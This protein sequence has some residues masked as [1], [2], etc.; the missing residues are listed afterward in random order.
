MKNRINKA[1]PVSLDEL[2]SFFIDQIY[3]SD[4]SI[5]N[6]QETHANVKDLILKIRK[7]WKQGYDLVL[8]NVRYPEKYHL[9]HLKKKQFHLTKEMFNQMT[10]RTFQE[11][12]GY[13]GDMM[14]EIY[15]IGSTFIHNKDFEKATTIF[16]FL[17]TLNPYVRW[18]WQGLGFAYQEQSKYEEALNAFKLAI[19]C[20]LFDLDGYEDA[21]RCCLSYKDPSAALGILDTGLSIIEHANNKENLEKLKNGLIEMKNFVKNL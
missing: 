16:V 21:V 4:A 10:Q 19:R 11:E 1:N 13:D 8:E 7:T 6:F 12:C 15:D 5:S 14:G 18:F 3:N 17:T 20:N 2:A 9:D